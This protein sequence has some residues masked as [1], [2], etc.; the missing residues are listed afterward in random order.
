[1]Q[2]AEQVYD[3][4]TCITADQLRAQGYAVPAHIPAD[5]WAV[6]ADIRM[7]VVGSERVG[8]K[9]HIRVRLYETRFR[10]QGEEIEA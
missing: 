7:Q 10:W 8:D 6:T 2:I 5:A 4:A 1:M 9:A 3:P